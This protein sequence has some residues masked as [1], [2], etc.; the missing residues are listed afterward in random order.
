[1]VGIHINQINDIV[2]LEAATFSETIFIAADE[3]DLSVAGNAAIQAEKSKLL[4]IHPKGA[5]ISGM[6]FG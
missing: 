4:V 2:Q 6:K 3:W 1:L 5:V